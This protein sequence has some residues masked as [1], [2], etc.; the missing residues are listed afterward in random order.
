[1]NVN[2]IYI[3]NKSTGGYYTQ[4]MKTKLS[5]GSAFSSCAR[6]TLTVTIQVYFYVIYQT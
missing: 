1:M 2:K 6:S 4:T 3:F 5:A